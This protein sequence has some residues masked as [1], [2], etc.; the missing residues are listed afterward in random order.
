MNKK[1]LDM[2]ALRTFVLGQEL[3][4]FNKVAEHL[5]RSTSAI[6]AQI[7]KLEQQVN[8][9]L[10][11][12]HGR[13]LKLT[14]AGELLF[15]YAQQLM[16]LNDG[17]FEKISQN[18]ISDHI[19]I[20]LSE[21]FSQE[22]LPLI[23]K[24]LS[25]SYPFIR[26]EAHIL[27]G[28]ELFNKLHQKQLDFIISW[29]YSDYLPTYTIATLPICW[30]SATPYLLSESVKLVSYHNSCL[31][32]QFAI[33]ALDQQKIKWQ[34]NFTS[35]NLVG[36]WAGVSS[37]LGITARTPLFLPHHLH[38]LSNQQLPTLPSIA[39]CLYQQT[40]SKNVTR[41]TEIM[42]D[43]IKQQIKANYI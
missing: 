23:L 9:P 19:R 14:A 1:N 3:G 18:Q 16:H 20:G 35:S 34:I 22:F 37:Q 40:Q 43:E 30:V 42:I 7:K 2:D 38:I 39:L 29:K 10:L 12:K 27:R 13:L 31:F 41:F 36:L 24:K 5:N 21:D 6:S 17:F 15:E 32:H 8:T 11:Y 25:D 26:V 28:Q 4:T 33:Q